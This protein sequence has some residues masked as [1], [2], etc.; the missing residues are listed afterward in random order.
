MRKLSVFVSILL[1]LSMVLVACGGGNAEKSTAGKKSSDS[2]TWIVSS[3]YPESNHIGQGIKD[4]SQKVKEATDGK[5][6]IELR[7]DGTLGYSSSD[8][9]KLVRDGTVP[10]A[11]TLLSSVAGDEPLLGIGSLPFLYR[12]FKEYKALGEV[13]RPY[14]DKVAEEKWNQKIL[15]IAPW[16]LTGFWTKEEIK[17]LEDFKGLKTRTFDDLTTRVSNAVGSSPSPLPFNEVY[18]A[19]S[20]GVIDS[21]MTSSTSAVDSKFWEV[22]DYYLPVSVMAGSNALAINLDEFNSLDKETQETMV[23]IGKEVEVDLWNRVAEL[24]KDMED[25]VNENGITT[26]QPSEE[27]VIELEKITEEIR[28]EWLSEAPPEAK[29]IIDNYY[30]KIGRN[31]K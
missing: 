12:D 27:L 19:L 14:F 25:T 24:G 30:K 28:K 22:L 18:S 13:T 2:V 6:N 29:E 9:L 17:S 10:M 15:Y 3:V 26:T 1:M 16:P 7:P 8:H 20:T 23:Q 31:G 4:F 5:V 21:V 11:D